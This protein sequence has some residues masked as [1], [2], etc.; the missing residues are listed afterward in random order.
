MGH[1]ADRPLEYGAVRHEAGYVCVGRDV[2]VGWVA[3][4]QGCYDVHGFAGKCPQ[5]GA[6]EPA[7]VL[8]F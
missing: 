1:G 2:V 3:G 6:H 4:G 7:V 5:C 8:E